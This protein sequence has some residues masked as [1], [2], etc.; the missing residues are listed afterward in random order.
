MVLIFVF[1]LSLYTVLVCYEC[2]FPIERILN[3]SVSPKRTRVISAGADE[4]L[5][6]WK[7]FDVLKPRSS[8][9]DTQNDSISTALLGG[10]Y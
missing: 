10:M 5:R 1:F 3:M 7:C 2:M 9:G 8:G 6:I 4:T